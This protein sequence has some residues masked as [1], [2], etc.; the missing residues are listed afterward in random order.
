MN[1]APFAQ[2]PQFC[3]SLL[4]AMMLW[5]ARLSATL[6]NPSDEQR[7]LSKSLSMLHR[8]LDC[9]N[10]QRIVQVLQAEVLLAFYYLNEGRLLEGNYH[11]S[12]ALSLCYS[13]KFHMIRSE[14]APRDGSID[15]L[16]RELHMPLNGISSA[17]E[18]EQING[19]WTVLRLNCYCIAFQGTEFPSPL[20]L[21]YGGV[22]TP[23]PQDTNNF[24]RNVCI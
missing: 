6:P 22:D 24:E 11:T 12:A 17:L 19:F 4:Y 5:G 20:T 1:D 15:M 9:A 2:P 16:S 23:W 14:R 13:S 8:D 18:E 21:P 3:Q 7:F 10:T